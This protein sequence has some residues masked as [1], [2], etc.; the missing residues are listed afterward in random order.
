MLSNNLI[1][2]I[3]KEPLGGAHN[4]LKWMA[5]EIKKTILQQT[6]ELSKIKPEKRVSQRLQKFCAMG[7]VTE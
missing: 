2:G 7:V 5:N 3:I 4:D 1:D 6:E